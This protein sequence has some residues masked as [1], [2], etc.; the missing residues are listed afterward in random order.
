MLLGPVPYQ[1]RDGPLPALRY[2]Q[3]GKGLT[4]PRS[5]KKSLIFGHGACLS[6]AGW[7]LARLNAVNCPTCML[8]NY[9]SGN[10]HGDGASLPGPAVGDM[11][12]LRL[13]MVG[14]R[15]I[16]PVFEKSCSGEPH[17][18][19]APHFSLQVNVTGTT[20]PR[21]GCVRISTL[22]P[23]YCAAIQLLS[24]ELMAIRLNGDF[25]I[26]RRGAT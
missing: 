26:A 22:Q 25:D 14:G 13:D 1:G 5:R 2:H 7:S 24:R 9:V 6:K 12:A 17:T 3:T 10:L 11:G 21:S 19:A 20:D 18:S 15:W 8:Q 16:S 23:G 4:R